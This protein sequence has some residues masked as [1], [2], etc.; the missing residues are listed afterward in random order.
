MTSSKLEP[1]SDK[2]IFVGYPKKTRGYEFYHPSDNKIF[3]ARNGT[4]LEKEFL[5]AITSGRKVD[6]EEIREPQ[7]EAPI[8]L[9]PE[10][11]DQAIEP[12]IAQDIPRRLDRIRNPPVRYGFLMSDEGDVLLVDQGEPETY[13]EAITC[14]ESDLWLEAM[15][16]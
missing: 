9:E 12:Q 6:L 15:K 2:V 13:L 10:Q 7:E 3:V 14:P 4:F 16:S 1:K 5:S 8:V 11:R